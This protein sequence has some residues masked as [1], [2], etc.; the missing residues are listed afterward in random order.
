MNQKHTAIFLAILAAI[1]YSLSSPFSKIL[2]ENLHPT[3]LAALLYLG[4]GFGTLI[5]GYVKKSI[6]KN[7]RE[8]QLE[9]ADLP[10]AVGMIILDVAA[11]ILLMIGLSETTA[12]NASLL[13]NFE[14]VATAVF[15]LLCFR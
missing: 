9:K 8:Q 4:A 1:L 12:A 5:I 6:L 3:M 2:L 11:P 14:S 13:N 7:D 10:F 15:A